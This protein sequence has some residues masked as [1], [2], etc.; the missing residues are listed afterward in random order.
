M[1]RRYELTDH[2]WDFWDA[3]IKKAIEWLQMEKSGLGI[4]SGNVGL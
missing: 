2:E 1:L 3:Y 4:S